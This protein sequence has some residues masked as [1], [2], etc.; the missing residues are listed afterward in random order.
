MQSCRLLC[1][2]ARDRMLLTVDCKSQRGCSSK[3]PKTSMM[4]LRQF[5]EWDELCSLRVT[6]S[7]WQQVEGAELVPVSPMEAMKVARS[8]RR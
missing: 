8:G 5:Q 1:K 4:V 2:E 6:G 3:R 7:L